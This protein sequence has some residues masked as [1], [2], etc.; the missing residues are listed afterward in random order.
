MRL[1]CALNHLLTYLLT[2]QTVPFSMTLNDLNPDFKD[3]PLFYVEYL[4]NG[5]SYRQSYNEI[6]MGNYT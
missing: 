1:S 5:T 6:P 3:T 4:R 2:Y